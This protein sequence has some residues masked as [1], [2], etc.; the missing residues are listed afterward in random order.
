MIE[1]NM[2]NQGRVWVADSRPQARVR[3]IACAAYPRCQQPSEEVC[4]SRMFSTA[5][6]AVAEVARRP[7][8]FA[9]SKA[10]YS[11]AGD[12]QLRTVQKVRVVTHALGS[13][14]GHNEPELFGRA[15]GSGY[16]D[17]LHSL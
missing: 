3:L 10:S 9:S 12:G 7:G 6:S 17:F 1:L 2:S 11:E 4:I 14:L 5:L 13:F 15:L 8:D 16:A